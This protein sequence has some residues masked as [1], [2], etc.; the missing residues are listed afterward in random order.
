[1]FTKKKPQMILAHHSSWKYSV[2]YAFSSQSKSRLALNS[3]LRQEHIRYL[4]SNSLSYLTKR[5]TRLYLTT[6]NMDFNYGLRACHTTLL[7]T[8]YNC[9]CIRETPQIKRKSR[10]KYKHRGWELHVHAHKT[11]QASPSNCLDLF[12]N[13]QDLFGTACI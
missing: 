7:K 9:A 8:N 12:R 11:P 6:R 3:Q 13:T 2:K 5:P 1:M 10:Y 4:E